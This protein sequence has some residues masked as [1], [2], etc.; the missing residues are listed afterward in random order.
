MS[1]P[2][3]LKKKLHKKNIKDKYKELALVLTINQR[4]KSR[5]YESHC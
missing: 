3:T 2:G 4:V 1:S 5:N